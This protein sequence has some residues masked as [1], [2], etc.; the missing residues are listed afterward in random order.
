MEIEEE[1]E[2]EEGEEE[3]EEEEEE[4]EKEEEEEEEK[5]QG[6]KDHSPQSNFLQRS[7]DPILYILHICGKQYEN[8][9][10]GTVLITDLSKAYNTV[11]HEILLQKMEHYGI[12]VRTLQLL[13]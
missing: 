3:E 8:N 6:T 13:P 1:E 11:D 2:E 4:T 10:I 12:R 7:G 5:E 9:D